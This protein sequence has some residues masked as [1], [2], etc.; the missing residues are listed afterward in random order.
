MIWQKASDVSSW[1]GAISYCEGLNLGG[2]EDWRLPNIKEHRSIIDYSKHDPAIDQDYIPDTPTAYYWS[3]TSA[4]SVIPN[5]AWVVDFTSGFMWDLIVKHGG[6]DVRFR[7]VRGEDEVANTIPNLSS[8]S[9]AAMLDNG[10]MDGLNGIEW[11]FSW[12]TVVGA[13]SYQLYVKEI[14]SS[15]PIINISSL[16]QALYHFESSDWIA[17][18]A[19]Q[20]TWKVR[21][22]VNGQWGDWSEI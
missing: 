6:G 11:D 10:R 15:V 14:S 5:D 19:N 12:N 8:P 17:N 20:F 3:S 9:D 18:S 21:A 16:N 13:S 4:R 7:C 2:Y 22:Y 1:W